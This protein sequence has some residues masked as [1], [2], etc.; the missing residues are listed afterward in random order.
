MCIMHAENKKYNVAMRTTDVWDSFVLQ[1]NLAS[2]TNN[3]KK[4]ETETD[5]NGKRKRQLDI[6]ANRDA[7]DWE[8]V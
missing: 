6:M 5:W 8:K 3:K 7:C 1:W 2:S 4:I